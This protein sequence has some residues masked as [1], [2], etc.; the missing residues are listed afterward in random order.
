MNTCHNGFKKTLVFKY[1][2]PLKEPE[3]LG[4]VVDSRSRAGNVPDIQDGTVTAEQSL[5]SVWVMSVG[6]S[7]QFGEVPASQRCDDLSL[8]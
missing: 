3:I 5:E 2:S 6:L 8:T 4:E 1:H 7:S